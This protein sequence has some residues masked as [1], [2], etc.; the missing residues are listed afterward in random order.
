MKTSERDDLI[1]A[2]HQALLGIPNTEDMGL[3]GDF[4]ELKEVVKQ[5]N[6]R[7]GKVENKQS[8]T[9]G[10]LIGLGILGSGGAGMGIAQLF[11]G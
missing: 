4:K 2:T 10:I 5:Q 3:V 11:G 9:K 1:K 7:I 8:K 6:R